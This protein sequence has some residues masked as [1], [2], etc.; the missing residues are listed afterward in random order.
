[1]KKTFIVMLL[2]FSFFLWT[3]IAFADPLDWTGFGTY[4]PGDPVT[5]TDDTTIEFT[6]D[7]TWGAVYYYN[8]FYMVP[9][10]AGILSFDYEITLGSDD[11]DDYLTFDIFDLLWA[12]ITYNE[13][14]EYMGGPLSGHFEIDLSGYQGDEIS[15]AWGFIEGDFDGTADSTAVISNID[16]TTSAVPILEPTTILLLGTGLAGLISAGRIRKNKR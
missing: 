1:M 16:L 9:D 7:L 3:G 8:D 14:P 13:F 6:E 11:D 4:D 15:L 12:V 5:R 10:N 2:C